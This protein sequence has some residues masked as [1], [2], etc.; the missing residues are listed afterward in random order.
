MFS[1]SSFNCAN[2]VL[3]SPMMLLIFCW[4]GLGS[5]AITS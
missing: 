5:I 1:R 4:I 3:Y 2:F